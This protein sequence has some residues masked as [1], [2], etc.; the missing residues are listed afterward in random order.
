MASRCLVD[1][2]GQG[3]GTADTEAK[4][5]AKLTKRSDERVDETGF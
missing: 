3:R 1:R 4:P 2:H 5:D